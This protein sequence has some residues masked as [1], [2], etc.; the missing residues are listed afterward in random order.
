MTERTASRRRTYRRLPSTLDTEKR[1]EASRSSPHRPRASHRVARA[2]T[3]ASSQKFV[4]PTVIHHRRHGVRRFARLEGCA[5]ECR[6]REHWSRS[7]PRERVGVRVLLCPRRARWIDE[8]EKARARDV[9][10]GDGPRRTHRVARGSAQR[11]ARWRNSA[12]VAS[13]GVAGVAWGA[14][15]LEHERG[16]RARETIET[17]AIRRVSKAMRR[18]GGVAYKTGQRIGE[19]AE[20][21]RIVH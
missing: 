11:R 16:A 18:A 6:R 1:F 2:P 12:L 8:E 9:V 20:R 7:R 13:G 5:R 19:F 15:M 21:S 14:E 10:R 3:L 17:R 4:S